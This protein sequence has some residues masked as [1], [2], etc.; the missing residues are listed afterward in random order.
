MMDKLKALLARCK[1]GVFVTVNEHRDYYA[2]AAKA[3]DDA[4]GVECPPR[5][6]P[7]VRAKMI[8]LD[9]IIQIQFYPDTP[10]G[11]H[12]IWHHNIDAA[13]DMALACVTPN[14]EVSGPKRR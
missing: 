5:I 6:A 13:L 1:C 11:S 12:Q 7:D 8:E 3:L 2:T 10:I 14:V 4:E 9:T